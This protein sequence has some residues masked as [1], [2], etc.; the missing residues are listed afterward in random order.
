MAKVAKEVK[1]LSP[2]ELR[3]AQLDRASRLEGALRNFDKNFEI[4]NTR[5]YFEVIKIQEFLLNPSN[6]QRD[7]PSLPTE[8]VIFKV[9]FGSSETGPFIEPR[10]ELKEVMSD[11][12]RFRNEYEKDLNPGGE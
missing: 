8:G 11:V 6:T 1:V 4:S 10:E 3:Q 9:D 7:A 2:S 12:V 5:E